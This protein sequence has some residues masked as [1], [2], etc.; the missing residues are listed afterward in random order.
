MHKQLT[1]LSH[2]QSVIIIPTKTHILI[3][4]YE[5]MPKHATLLVKVHIY[6]DYVLSARREIVSRVHGQSRVT[7]YT[8]W[9]TNNLSCPDIN[10]DNKITYSF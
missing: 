9:D 10:D 8:G 5:K 3:R 7:V 1:N 6:L 2:N 4:I